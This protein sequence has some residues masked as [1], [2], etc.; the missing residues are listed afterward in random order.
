MEHT[1]IDYPLF[2]FIPHPNCGTLI[3]LEDCYK[4]TIISVDN[5]MYIEKHWFDLNRSY[6]GL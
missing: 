5:G 1:K 3:G 6:Y 2:Y 4:D